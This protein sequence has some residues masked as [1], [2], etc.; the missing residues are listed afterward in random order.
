MKT[1]KHFAAALIALVVHFAIVAAASEPRQEAVSPQFAHAIPNIAGK[2]LTSVVVSF[3]PGAKATPHRHGDAFVYAYVLS[4]AVRSQINDEPAKVYQMGQDWYEP[5]GSHHLVT[6]N[7][8]TTESAKL[9]VI[10]V[11]NTGDA[12]KIPDQH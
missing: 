2:S 11:A 3:T 10:F 1:K 12:L 6:E 4:G 5:P 8:S 7:V 9:L